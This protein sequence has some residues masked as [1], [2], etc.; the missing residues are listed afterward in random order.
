VKPCEP[1]PGDVYS[2]ATERIANPR[3]P[4]CYP[5]W[6]VCAAEGGRIVLDKPESAGGEWKHDPPVN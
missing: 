5:V 2:V 4:A 3:N 1:V 6:T